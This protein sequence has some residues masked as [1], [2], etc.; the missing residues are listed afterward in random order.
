M[1]KTRDN[2]TSLISD[3]SIIRLDFQRL[4]GYFPA[5][6][7]ISLCCA[8]CQA[9]LFVVPSD[10]TIYQVYVFPHLMYH[11]L[12][13]LGP[14]S[15]RSDSASAGLEITCQPGQT[16]HNWLGGTEYPET[17]CAAKQVLHDGWPVMQERT[18]KYWQALIGHGRNFDALLPKELPERK[19]LLQT[20]DDVAVLIKAKQSR[21]GA[22]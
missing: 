5:P 1:S 12:L 11:Q 9:R 7:S 13:I 21:E 8:D 6:W 10:T 15:I 3:H 4:F 16:L 2:A 18:I 20:F 22:V 17:I 14:A 19:K